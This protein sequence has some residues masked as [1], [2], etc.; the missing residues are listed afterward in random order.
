MSD[1]FR[2]SEEVIKSA[3]S[4]LPLL[5]SSLNAVFGGQAEAGGSLQG[6]RILLGQSEHTQ[7]WLLRHGG[8]GSRFPSTLSHLKP[9]AER[10]TRV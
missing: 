8:Q 10:Q 6:W 2:V 5:S 3:S 7:S 4:P 1:F 9:R